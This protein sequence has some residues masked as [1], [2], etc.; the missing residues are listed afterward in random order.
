LTLFFGL[1]FDNNIRWAGA[2]LFI[3]EFH[4]ISPGGIAGGGYWT[5]PFG[6]LPGN[7]GD[8]WVSKTWNVAT[9]AFRRYAGTF[10][11]RPSATFRLG[12]TGD[13]EFAVAEEDHYIYLEY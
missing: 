9:D 12:L 13:D 11:Y 1:T 2:G 5:G 8:I 4:L 6:Q 3:L 10:L 7:T